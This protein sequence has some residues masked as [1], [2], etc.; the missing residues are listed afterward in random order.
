MPG[1]YVRIDSVTVTA[2]GGNANIGFTNIPSTFDDIAIL[3]SGRTTTNP[4]GE[5][6]MWC[7]LGFN[8]QGANINNTGRILFGTGS[9]AGSQANYTY[10]YIPSSGATASTFGNTFMYFPNYAGSTQKSF[11]IDSVMENN[12]A[13]S[14]QDLATG[15]WT[16]TAAINAINIFPRT[17]NFAQHSTA[18][19][20]GIKRN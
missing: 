17:G 20:Y 1:S 14:M 12:A 6:R 13:D 16:G 9:S 15:T 8:G 19:L 10:F 7:E 5:S 4:F 18:V 11:S 3:F 2:A